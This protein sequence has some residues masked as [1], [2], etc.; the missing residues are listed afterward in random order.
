M[1]V[2]GDLNKS[3]LTPN[4]L[5]LRHSLLNDIPITTIRCMY[6]E[7]NENN[8]SADFVIIQPENISYNVGAA[9]VGN[10]PLDL[11][12]C[13][14]DGKQF[15][16]YMNWVVEYTIGT[17]R[18]EVLENDKKGV[19]PIPNSLPIESTVPSIRTDKRKCYYAHSMSLY[20]SAQEKRDIELLESMGF[21]V[22]NPNSEKI[23]A[24]VQAIKNEYEPKGW[25]KEEISTG[26]MKY[27]LEN[28]IPLCDVLAFRS[29]IDFKIGAGV[30]SEIQ[31]AEEIGIPVFELP[32]LIH[33]RAVGVSETREYLQQLGQR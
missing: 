27:F 20:G 12:E 30:Y 19:S 11:V 23:K 21:E 4:Q 18:F 32:T 17:Q 6:G 14:S 24:D 16:F 9:T 8:R 29:F 25:T 15:Q 10:R 13:I 5:I 31:K 2:Y 28:V 7:L 22:V 3:R 26:I 33:Q 1:K